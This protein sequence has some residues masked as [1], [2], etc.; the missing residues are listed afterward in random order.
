VALAEYGDAID[1]SR[2]EFC[3]LTDIGMLQM[4]VS[5]VKNALRAFAESKE[6]RA[7]V[8]KGDWGTGKTFVW[9]E[10]VRGGRR[11]FHRAEY[12]YVSL[13]GITSLADMKRAIFTS[14]VRQ[15]Q[16]GDFATLDS[17]KENLKRLDLG[18]LK[19]WGRKASS[20]ANNVKLPL[21]GGIG[22]IVDSVQFASIS[23]VL[24]CIDDFERRGKSLT[25]RDVLGLISNL[26]EQRQCSVILIL[27][28][29]ALELTDEF[30]SFNEKV[31]DYEVLY[32]PL[33]RECAN[34]V[35]PIS[36]SEY[37]SLSKN[38]ERLGI[39]N[40]RV[41]NKIKFFFD[42]IRPHL[43]SV[44]TEILDKVVLI[45]PLAIFATYGSGACPVDVSFISGPLHRPGLLPLDK[46]ATAAQKNEQAEL[47]SKTQWL[48]EY[49]FYH[50]EEL[51]LS[52]VSL[53]KRGYADEEQFGLLI[54]TLKVA[55]QHSRDMARLSEAWNMFHA[56]LTDNQLE[57]VAAFESA[58]VV[59][60]DKMNVRD[61][62]GVCW[63][64]DQL[65]LH[66]EVEK[67]IESHF[68][69]ARAKTWY[70]DH[71]DVWQWPSFPALSEQLKAHF[72]AQV[73]D[74]PIE[75]LMDCA[76]YGSGFSLSI[77]RGFKKKTAD[78][79]YQYFKT[80]NHIR[81]K[82]YLRN[83]L[84]TSNTLRHDDESNEANRHIFLCTYKA[85]QRLGSES[86]INKVRLLGFRKYDAA[87]AM[88]LEEA[89]CPD[90]LG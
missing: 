62:D 90:S 11:D 31:F 48:N 71:L 58:L 83:C 79:F 52:I 55:V 16:A 25:A 20:H 66:Q 18:W 14:I 37:S 88:I 28:E 33:A 64:F 44:P 60:I 63:L 36:R 85:I 78:E 27:N 32:E 57:V 7:I 49:G 42:L 51:D 21:I 13:F 1:I 35:F 47:M 40:I 73:V 76:Y 2:S 70:Q 84:D 41:L 46:D 8:L 56:S 12:S 86:A 5:R 80:A 75:E 43:S 22:S 29:N 53:V 34:I 69:V 59:C 81:T 26:V 39:S 17:L 3:N 68:K 10:V 50:A 87:Y 19:S 38:S 61:V 45:L 23:D 65:G 4:S 72:D 24:I 15:D 89:G 74:V 9:N 82:E 30:F 6:A 77:L 67:L 54:E